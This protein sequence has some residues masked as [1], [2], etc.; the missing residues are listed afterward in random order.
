MDHQLA[1]RR[2]GHRHPGSSLQLTQATLRPGYAIRIVDISEHGLLV[3]TTRPLRPG[4]R[5]HVRLVSEHWSVSVAALVLRCGVSRVHPDD[6]VTYRGAL[7]F[8][9]TAPDVAAV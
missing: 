4:T 3:E 1:E 7:R 2:A 6:G 9:K 8:E 5:V